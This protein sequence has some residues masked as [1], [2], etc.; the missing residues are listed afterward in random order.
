[1]VMARWPRPSNS[2][3]DLPHLEPACI[4]PRIGA[5]GIRRGEIDDDHRDRTVGLGLQDEAALELQRRAEQRRQ[6]DRL[7]E[8]LRRP[9]AGRRAWQGSRPAPGRA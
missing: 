1:M 3:D 6:H 4:E 5:Q 8:Q 7:T 9:A 2:A